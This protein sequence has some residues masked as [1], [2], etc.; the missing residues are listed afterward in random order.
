MQTNKQIDIFFLRQLLQNKEVAILVVVGQVL[1]IFTKLVNDYNERS[2]SGFNNFQR[3][4]SVEA[5]IASL[6]LIL[7]K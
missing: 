1:Q 7:F 4:S 5:S 2:L 6:C 3:A